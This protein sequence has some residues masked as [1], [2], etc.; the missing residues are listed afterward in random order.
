MKKLFAIVLKAAFLLP[1][2]ASAQSALDGTWKID[3]GQAQLSAK[4]DVYLLQAG[5]YECKTCVPPIRITAD[6][7]IHPVT[8]H[9]YYDAMS[10]K[11]IDDRNIQTTRSKNGKVVENDKTTVAPDGAAASDE[12]IDSSATSGAP[13]T[14]KS[15]MSRVATGPAGSHAIS[16]SWRTTKLANISDN[17]ITFTYKTQ[18][19]ALNMTTPTGQSFTAK[20]DGTDAPYNGDPGTTSVSV[21][22]IGKMTLEETDKRDGK[23]ISVTRTVVAANGKTIAIVVHD[24]LHGTTSK[25]VGVKQ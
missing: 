22:R 6:G 7:Q 16:G 4:P 11:V 13:V 23:V 14:G 1:V 18:G 20:V 21:K 19:D 2:L 9:P 15:E 8:G 17:G 25:F 3:L 10:V 5:M 12:F 24:T